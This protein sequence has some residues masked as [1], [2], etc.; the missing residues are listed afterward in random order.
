M[1]SEKTR[2][3]LE[4]LHRTQ[5]LGIDLD[6]LFTLLISYYISQIYKKN[7]Y[8]VLIIMV[9]ISII[10]HRTFRI[11]TRINEIIFGRV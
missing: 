3:T 11:N 2:K 6:I 8:Q 1:F 4:E 7:F 5:I 9:L 10:V